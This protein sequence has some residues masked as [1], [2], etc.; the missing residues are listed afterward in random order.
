M[1]RIAKSVADGGPTGF[2]KRDFYL[3]LQKRADQIREPGETREAAFARYARTDPEGRLLLTAY[4]TVG[5][6]DYSGEQDNVED[7]P[8]TNEGYRRLMDLAAERRR[9]GETIQQTFARLYADLDY[10]QLVATEKRMHPGRVA[11]AMGIG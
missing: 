1:I 8:Q 4:K 10:R 5:G 6:E 9:D 7:E 11:K 2:M 3:E